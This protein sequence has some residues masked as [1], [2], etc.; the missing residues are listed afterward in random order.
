VSDVDARLWRARELIGGVLVPGWAGF[1]LFEQWSAFGGH[2]AFAERMTATSHGAAAIAAEVIFG[3]APIVLWIGIE[4]RL[5]ARSREPE[6]LRGALAESPALA[7]R[8][9]A[10]STGASWLFFG[11]LVFHAVW[12]FGSKI[13][14]GSDPVRTWLRL[15][16]GLGTWAHAVPL[17][18]GLSAFSIHVAAAAPRVSAVMGW[19]RTAESRRA[20]RLAGLII[21]VAFLALYAELAGWHAAGAGVVW[22]L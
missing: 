21:A 7:N 8:L 15:R 19:S 20:A 14:E 12:L 11:W 18:I 5:R 9:G 10:I 6:E 1:H 17:A 4:A 13:A 2:R 22:P 16:D 3:L